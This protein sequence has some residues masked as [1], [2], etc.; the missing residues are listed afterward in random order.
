MR[1]WQGKKEHKKGKAS[2]TVPGRKTDAARFQSSFVFQYFKNPVLFIRA[3]KFEDLVGAV[4]ICTLLSSLGKK[5]NKKQTEKQKNTAFSPDFDFLH[6]KRKKKNKS[7]DACKNS[8]SCFCPVI[9]KPAGGLKFFLCQLP[10]FCAVIVPK[11]LE[12]HIQIC[13]CLHSTKQKKKSKS[14]AKLHEPFFLCKQN[15]F[16]QL[17]FA[18]FFPLLL[19]VLKNKEDV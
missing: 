6:K 8:K 11:P 4:Y 1:I 9:P 18:L 7:A 10:C 12:I 17:S 14:T 16:H 13:P 15:F 19:Y 3:V 5:R 2:G